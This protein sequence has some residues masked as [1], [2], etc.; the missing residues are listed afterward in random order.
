MATIRRWAPR[1][2]GGSRGQFILATLASA[3]IV[4][5]FIGG[6]MTIVGAYEML[7]S[8]SLWQYLLVA[9]GAAGS[10]ARSLVYALI[11]LGVAGVVAG[12]LAVPLVYLPVMKWKLDAVAWRAKLFGLAFVL[13]S[14]GLLIVPGLVAGAL[15][16]SVGKL[17]RRALAPKGRE[18]KSTS[19]QHRQRDRG[20][21]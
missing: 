4:F 6:L 19:V 16:Y 14:P 17:S 20:R 3:A 7:R 5:A 11:G 10:L 18:L 9:P 13:L 15:M 1:G 12:L 2:D 8:Q 21:S